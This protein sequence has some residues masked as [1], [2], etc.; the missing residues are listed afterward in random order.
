M[1][2]WSAADLTA[3]RIRSRLRGA[4]ARH[5]RLIRRPDAGARLRPWYRPIFTTSNTKPAQYRTL[6]LTGEAVNLLLKY[7]LFEHLLLKR[8]G[9]LAKKVMY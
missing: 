9:V 1:S 4:H 7:L 2:C 6:P 3:E 8:A 5:G